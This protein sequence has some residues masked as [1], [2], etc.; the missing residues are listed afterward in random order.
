MQ[1]R[2]RAFTLLELLVVISIMA[3]LMAV[4]LPSLSS[5]RQSAKANVC[6]SNLKGIGSALS[7]YLNENDDRLPPAR[8]ERPSPGSE[9]FYVND[10]RRLAP[11]WQWFLTTDHG[12]VI[13]PSRFNAVIQSRGYF[14]DTDTNRATGASGTTM[15]NKLFTCPSLDDE[16]FSLDV[17][18]GAY[19]YNYQYLGNA[20]R[21]SNSSRWDN[22]AV[23]MHRIRKPA[24]MIA[25]GDSRGAGSPHGAHS[26]TLDP[27]RMAIERNARTF[28]PNGPSEVE[29]SG[30]ND[31]PER[32]DED[33]FAY[34]PVEARHKSKGNVVFL[35][36]HA[37]AK[38]LTQ[39]GYQ[40]GDGSADNPLGVLAKPNVPIPIRDP[41]S[42]TYTATNRLWNGDDA[43]PLA[44]EH[45]PGSP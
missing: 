24:G 9:E 44:Y 6:L 36:G 15:T 38:T 4:L 20:R 40:V 2:K 31:V 45:A 13:E 7:L 35:D 18:D 16:R 17:R 37:S 1:L 43:D 5:A 12:P 26:Y 41:D 27:P 3:L 29:D 22:F 23:G 14:F 11:R 19:G 42:G 8:L 32:F 10:D 21:E 34:S 25:F 28:G 30:Q 39:L 33:L